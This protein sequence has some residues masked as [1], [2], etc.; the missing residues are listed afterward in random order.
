MANSRLYIQNT[1]RIMQYQSIPLVE[2]KSW[3]GQQL[4]TSCTSLLSLCKDK[5]YIDL[6]TL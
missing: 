1:T 3:G 6:C 5:L 4:K 2:Q